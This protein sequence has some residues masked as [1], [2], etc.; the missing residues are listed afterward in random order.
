[1]PSL[2]LEKTDKQGQWEPLLLEGSPKFS[3]AKECFARVKQMQVHEAISSTEIEIY[4]TEEMY[5][6]SLSLNLGS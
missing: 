6:L 5:N 2:I 1:M 4:Q 3:W